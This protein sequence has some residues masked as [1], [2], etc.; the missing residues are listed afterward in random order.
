[1][2]SSMSSYN[3]SEHIHYRSHFSLL[4]GCLSP[5]DICIQ[6]GQ[7]GASAAAMVDIN[8]FY[9]MV[10]FINAAELRGIKPVSGVD[11][12]VNGDILFTLYPRTKSAYTWIN[13]LI[14][15][16][17][18]G[19][20]TGD[21]IDPVQILL[22]QGWPDTYVLSHK[23]SVLSRFKS[24]DSGDLY[25]ELRY[26][27]P[28]RA[29]AAWA[30]VEG[31]GCA[32][33]SRVVFS[34]KDDWKLYR[35]LAAV[36]EN[37]RLKD[38]SPDSMLEHGVCSISAEQMENYFAAVPE[39]LAVNQQIMENC[40]SRRFIHD[41]YVF[42]SFQQLD[43]AGAYRR[44][45][46]LCL[47]GVHRRYGK[48]THEIT[49]RL[50]YELSII[51]KKGFSGYFLV[52][53]DIVRRS[54]RTCGRGSSAASIVSYLLGI[55]H[56]DPLK[57]NLF[58]ERFLNMGR[59]DPPDIDVDFPWDEREA[60]FDYIFST[61]R[62]HS[63]MV[64]DHI[65]FGPRS[66]I[67]EPAKAFGIDEQ[68]IGRMM[69]E[70][71]IGKQSLPD[72][73]ERAA[74]RLRGMP[75]HIGT[76]PGGVVIT[77]EPIHEYSHIQTT[78]CGLQVIAWEKDAA[79][80]AGLVKIDI[81][82]NRSLGVLRDS[83]ELVNS[84][85]KDP[86][87]WEAFCPVSN[88]PTREQIEEGDTLGIFYVESPATRQLLKKMGSGSYEHLVI[89]SSIIRPAANSYIN[90]FVH[91]L[92]GGEYKPLHP[93]VEETLKETFGIM[94]YQED[95]SR[96]AIDLCGFT[97]SEADNLRKILAKKDRETKIGNVRELFF[98]KG[99]DRGIN[100]Q[101][102]E[103]L[104]D[105]VLS[106]TG[107]SFCKAHSAS[108]ALVSYKLAWMKRFY[109]LQFMVSVINNGGGFY[110]RQVYVNAVRR[111]GFPILGPDI[112]ASSNLFRCENRAMR[113]GFCQLK[114]I[115][116]KIIEKII[117]ER[118]DNGNYT[119]IF[120]FYSRISCSHPDL[121]ALIRSG[122][123]DSIAGP[124]TRPQLFW[125]YF[126]RSDNCYLFEVRPVPPAINDY[127]ET[128]KLLDEVSHLGIIH[129]RH[130]VSI[131]LSRAEHYC[132]ERHIF[133][134]DSQKIHAYEGKQISIL[135]MIVTE[136]QVMT[137]HKDS[138]SFVS[139]EDQFSLFESVMFPK[140]YTSMV[141]QLTKGYVF[142]VQGRVEK[143][144]G[145]HQIN[146]SCL[147]PVN[148]VAND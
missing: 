56:V 116:R 76:H 7:T 98:S 115:N 70:Y 95:V 54:Q 22:N 69:R 77:P 125:L 71:R 111:M 25:A 100:L 36:R 84:G 41:T 45:H 55:T 112:N 29:F 148:R 122:A 17:L 34:Q 50:N 147:I 81:L 75:R 110:S 20:R 135:G 11:I 28:Y 9:G 79:E 138:M 132:C 72:Y 85:R 19:E 68:E 124:Y 88:V 108:Y 96:I 38:L 62:G 127:P 121:R 80:D 16:I 13:K 137:K 144:F 114:E 104:W 39:A 146:V 43:D 142:I 66:C 3:N 94:V 74:F 5:E 12:A 102:L 139:F 86:L 145:V 18:D 131:F 65:T 120:D 21:I 105:G 64:A 14:S 46:G 15:L 31:L 44:L 53:H 8:N 37:C 42:P 23:R 107:Y 118:E 117:T 33:V 91:R 123:L 129:S 119:T 136:K 27:H 4:R 51:R 52:V 128:V 10:R 35:L 106:F 141:E 26:K 67:R 97:A 133:L 90:E 57:Y 93:I 82:G 48:V 126:H 59:K 40:D 113:I 2:L 140:V 49:K 134:I 92:H 24:R 61:Y 32:A 101:I 30:G 103:Q 130:P 78:D 1:M 63:A 143:E 99:L 109:P 83:I 89:A 73:L 6:A 47:E 87:E 58:F 60:A